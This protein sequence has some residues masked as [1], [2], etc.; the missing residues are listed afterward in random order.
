[1]LFNVIFIL[2]FKFY[3][4]VV[5]NKNCIYCKHYSKIIYIKSIDKII[6]PLPLS[7]G[8]CK[9]SLDINLPPTI[10]K[11]QSVEEFRSNKKFDNCGT[12]G[13]FFKPK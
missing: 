9:L 12:C 8:Y 10:K 4:S 6:N 7:I 13:K 11:Y 2:F 5:I 1:M 3:Q